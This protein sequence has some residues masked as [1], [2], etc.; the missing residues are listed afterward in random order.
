[1][2]PMY[3]DVKGRLMIVGEPLYFGKL[4]AEGKSREKIAELMKTRVNELYFKYVENSP[5]PKIPAPTAQE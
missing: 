2:Y 3:Y 1:M 5:A 4:T